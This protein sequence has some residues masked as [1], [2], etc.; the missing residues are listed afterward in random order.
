MMRK[1]QV[2]FGG[3]TV[4]K[5]PS[6]RLATFLPYYAVIGRI[7]DRPELRTRV[8]L[9]GEV[10]EIPSA[11]IFQMPPRIRDCVAEEWSI[12]REGT[13]TSASRNSQLGSRPR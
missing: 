4:E 8:G 3:G 9:Y 2:R 1:Y 13:G 7:V 10:F 5:Y 6:G 11:W 12:V